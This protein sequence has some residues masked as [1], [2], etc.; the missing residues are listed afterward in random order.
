M[1][2]AQILI[3]SGI[4]TFSPGHAV[5]LSLSLSEAS[6]FSLRPGVCL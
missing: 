3:P 6:G 2:K 1:G 5:F 4:S